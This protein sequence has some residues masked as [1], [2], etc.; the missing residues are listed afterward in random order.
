MMKKTIFNFD[1]YR[2]FLRNYVKELPKSRGA[3]KAWAR[4]LEVH[5][6]LVSQVMVGK[7]D[8]TEEQA[9]ELCDFLG[10]SALE[11]DYFL[12][13]L[14]LE[15]AGTSKLKK[16]HQEKIKEFSVKALKLADRIDT[17]RLLTDQ[18]SAT[19]YSSWMYSAIRL[20][21]SIGEG[22]TIDDISE[23]LQLPRSQVLAVV[24]FLRD[25]GFIKQNGAR[26]EIGSRYTHLGKGSPYLNRHHSNWRVKA[27]QKMDS[28]S[29]QELMYTAPFSISEKDFGLL[30][31]QMVGVIQ[32]FLKTVKT[33]EGEVVA[34]FNLDLFKL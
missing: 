7:R 20:F 23:K 2:D 15:R 25:T 9:L 13:L 28:V 16:Y 27:L 34:C 17:E 21:C 12:E 32:E 1:N 3:L 19:F 4:H 26:F 31:E 5:T 11:K 33:S 6:T 22:Q 29:D 14:R 24:E 18:E 10:L 8:F 30:R